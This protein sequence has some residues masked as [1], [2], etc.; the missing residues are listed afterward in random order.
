MIP[1]RVLPQRITY[2]VALGQNSFGTSY[3]PA[4][5]PIPARVEGQ[6]KI[7]V[8][9]AGESVVS[10]AKVFLQPGDH[11][12]I[13]DEVSLPNG[14]VVTVVGRAEHVGRTDVELVTLDVAP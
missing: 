10:T 13:D 4:S 3:G 12:G 6:R 14:D 1:A 2:R 7:V 9:A 8:T 11:P 5:D